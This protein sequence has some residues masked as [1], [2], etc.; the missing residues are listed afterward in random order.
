MNKKGE[1]Y[2][3][4]SCMIELGAFTLD[5]E[6]EERT[7]SWFDRTE[8]TFIDG[9][10]NV[11]S[12]TGPHSLNV[13]IHDN[14]QD[15]GK[16]TVVAGEVYAGPKWIYGQIKNRLRIGVLKKK[17]GHV[18]DLTLPKPA[19]RNPEQRTAGSASDEDLK[20]IFPDYQLILK[21][22]GVAVID[23]R[24]DLLEDTS[25]RRRFLCAV[26][27]EEEFAPVIAFAITRILALMKEYEQMLEEGVV[28]DQIVSHFGDSGTDKHGNKKGSIQSTIAGGES[29]HI[30]FKPAI[31]YN[32]SRATNEDN[33]TPS[34]DYNVS[35]NVVRT[36]A[37]FLNAEGGTLFIGVSDD[38][39]AYGLESDLA[40]TAR[41]D[42]DGLENELTQLLSSSISNEV[43]ATKVKVTLP[44]FQ[45]KVIGQVDVKPANSPVF[46]KTN[47]HKSK[48][49][50]RIGNAT[51][52]MSVESAFNYISQH[53]WSN[54][55]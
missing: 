13:E 3:V 16:R 27:D 9:V 35:D 43:V 8:R 32:H 19:K 17:V 40:L 15:D 24:A 50:V 38:G 1:P 52:I 11:Y 51:N 48:F 55:E 25:T 6:A 36:V 22:N 7:G 53:E 42:L 30:E 10:V 37:G 49:Y 33:Y 45:G 26:M 39:D 2:L 47:R 31:W 23:S 12:L 54:N 14:R 29:S 28:E 20:Q 18:F 21:S 44:K 5:P 4:L 34:K 46:M 41:K